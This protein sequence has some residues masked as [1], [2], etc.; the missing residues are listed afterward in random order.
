MILRHLCPMAGRPVRAIVGLILLGLLFVAPGQASAH[1]E[2]LGTEPAD[3][4]V[5]DAGPTR[6]TVRFAETVRPLIARLT[7]PDQTTLMLDVPTVTDGVVSYPLPPMTAKG[8]YLLSWRVTSADGHPLAG[9]ALFSIGHA[10]EVPG[11]TQ[12]APLS[13]QAG[14]WLA[15]SVLL[16]ALLFGA[17]GAGFTLI[18]G[19]PAPHL[20]KQIAIAG[21]IA[22]PLV[23]AF[24]GLDLLGASPDAL[25][26]RDPWH[27]AVSGPPAISLVFAVAALGFA[28]VRNGVIWSAIAALIG[29]GV[30]A[31]AAGH[32]ATAPPQLI[33]R[34]VIAL[35]VIAAAVWVGALIPLAKLVPLEDGRGALTRFSRVIPFGL[36]F[37]LATGFAIAV[38]QLGRVGALWQTGYG[39]VL[40]VKLMLVAGL[41]A[42]ALWNRL[43]L[44]PLAQTGEVRPLVRAI[45]LEILLAILV[46]G[47]A[48]LW[49]YTPP[50]RSLGSAPIL[51]EQAVAGDHASAII[52]LNT[53]RSGPVSV[54][55]S[56]LRLDGQPFTP[57]ETR[58]EF[59]KPAY[60]LG[61]FA[62]TL[63]KGQL[64]AG[65][66]V[67]PMDGF[68]V[69]RM[70]F[71]V[72][73]FRSEQILD[74]VTLDPAP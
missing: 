50:P 64:D 65:R 37:L 61:P 48:A 4:V 12:A 1:A 31:A 72:S 53:N 59:S 24:Q 69:L 47:V 17:G 35:H 46:I 2:L 20:V 32:A 49:R 27:E 39:R 51:V 13:T 11:D 41:L 3:G 66:F 18:S 25:M 62:R 10:S 42:V 71:L 57:L 45:R 23:A 38:V 67:L 9:G 26:T 43:R 7:L 14:L 56:D 44:T 74:I 29:V 52:T 73:D 22:V 58:I 6:F 16:T 54:T 34:P 36:A 8:S 60:G 68:W 28:L 15:R 33:M 21:L 30:A 5:L 19:R 55:L 40:L 70:T 63:P